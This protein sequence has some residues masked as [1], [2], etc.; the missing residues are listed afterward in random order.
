MLCGRLPFDDEYIPTLFKKINSGAFIMPNYLLQ[1]TRQII[2]SM[3]QVD[4]LKRTTIPIIRAA[5]WFNVDLPE[6][7][8]AQPDIMPVRED[9]DP[10]IVNQ[11]QKAMGFSLDTIKFALCE[12]SNNQIKV[13]YQLIADRKRLVETGKKSLFVGLIQPLKR[14]SNKPDDIPEVLPR[15]VTPISS[16]AELTSSMSR[17]TIDEDSGKKKT[18]ARWHFGIRSRSP[19]LDIMLELYRALQ[20]VGIVIIINLAMENC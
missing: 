10:N 16:V 19:P 11:V 13:A 14:I 2:A 5:A 7:L 6:Y 3:L 12:T 17:S 8:K 15:A 18:R 4:P 20:N 9:A 1:E